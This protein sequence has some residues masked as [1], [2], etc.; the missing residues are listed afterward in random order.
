MREVSTEP[1]VCRWAGFGYSE[2]WEEYSWQREQYEQKH[3]GRKMQSVFGKWKIIL[4]ALEY[5]LNNPAELT[6]L[7]SHSFVSPR[8]RQTGKM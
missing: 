8:V 3:R 7:C 6:A 5:A 1:G 4:L 2:V